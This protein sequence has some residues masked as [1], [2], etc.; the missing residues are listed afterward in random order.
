MRILLTILFTLVGVIC[1]AQ[2]LE[3]TP[4][5]CD[6]GKIREVDG[7]VKATFT[8]KNISDRAYILNYSYSG[9]GCIASDI[10]KKPLMPN[11]SR[12]IEI[13]FN[14]AGRPGVI[15]KE[16][17]MISDNRKQKDILFITGEVIPRPKS[18]KELYPIEAIEGVSLSDDMLPMGVMMQGESSQTILTIYN[19][20][21][22]SATIEAMLADGS[23]GEVALSGSKVEP[24]REI[25]LDFGFN[26]TDSIY[27]NISDTIYLNINGKRWDK[28]IVVNG[29]VIYNTFNLTDSER[30]SAP[31]AIISPLN[32]EV[33]KGE[34]VEIAI[35]NNG[36]SNLNILD[37]L[38]ERGVIEYDLSTKIVKPQE[39][40]ILK[41]E[42][43]GD[44][45][46]SVTLLLNDPQQ[47]ITTIRLRKQK[48]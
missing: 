6:L 10:S 16:V 4:A 11:K 23:R 8:I 19:G 38:V 3:I 29:M 48:L 13:E 25:I 31:I 26:L 34:S 12:E 44:S 40:G 9:C 46:A 45:D 47:P 28:G 32:Y 20:G 39:S 36:K 22:K 30:E 43:L 14:P 5:T 1:S 24:N 15:R 17:V 35:R 21:N 42:M 41:I 27:G 2:Q 33:T 37:I 18:V 7:V